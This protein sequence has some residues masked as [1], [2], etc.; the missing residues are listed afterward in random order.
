MSTI[1][2]QTIS[3][4]VKLEYIP[5]GDAERVKNR[6]LQMATKYGFSPDE[7]AMFTFIE[8]DGM[9]PKAWNGSCAGIIQ[10]CQSQGALTVGYSNAEEIRRLSVLQQLDLTDRYFEANNLKKGADLSELYLTVLNPASRAVKDPN[11]DLGVPGQQ[12]Q[13]LY[14]SRGVITRNSIN[15]A[16]RELTAAKLKTLVTNL[17]NSSRSNN[18]PGDYNQPN[19]NLGS[20]LSAIKSGL[21]NGENCPPPPYTQQ[22]RII[23]T[24]CKSVISSVS[25]SGGN[26]M[27]YAAPGIAAI[28]GS[29][30]TSGSA[31]FIGSLNPG[32][33]I[34]PAEGVLTSPF[35]PR[36]GR[37][38]AGE[39]IGNNQG[40][41]IYAS[42]DGI[43]KYTVTGCTQRNRGAGG[44][45]ECG[46]GGYGNSIGIDHPQGFFTLYAHL[47]DVLVKPNEK[48]KQGQQI[49]TMGS[50]GGS[51]NDHIHWEIRKGGEAGT[52]VNPSLY[53][54]S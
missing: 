19:S 17:P 33:F 16:I 52:P 36:F 5:P 49:G 46:G 10:F 42:A 48:V 40:T 22:A 6:I 15:K 34:K 28:G 53:V 43:V 45:D 11:A 24:G 12:A 30:V 27:G 21:F 39:D 41:P 32:G 9:D 14:D 23:Y 29:S 18:L 38:H 3:R 4:A 35:G 20:S 31:P 50:T 47:T 54:K 2:D 7:F 1:L 8:S 51:T 26:G 25:F 44:G 13:V 37:L